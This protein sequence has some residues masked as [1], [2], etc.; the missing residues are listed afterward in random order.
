MFKTPTRF[1]RS[2]VFMLTFDLFS[3]WKDQ[4]S[5]R[6]VREQMAAALGASGPEQ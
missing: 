2:V 6:T 3:A 5:V 4:A 1:G